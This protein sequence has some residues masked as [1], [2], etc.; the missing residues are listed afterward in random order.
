MVNT[1]NGQTIRKI[2]L[3]NTTIYDSGDTLIN[4]GLSMRT[5]NNELT[6]LFQRYSMT[7]NKIMGDELIGNSQIRQ[8]Y[9][10]E[11]GV[12]KE[13][14]KGQIAFKNDIDNL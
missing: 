14:S 8:F 12:F 4:R 2:T 5:I 6:K 9:T 3:A 1:H 11:D 13:Y 7:L 10:D